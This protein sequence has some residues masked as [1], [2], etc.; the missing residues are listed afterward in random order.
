MLVSTGG[1]R[2]AWLV[3]GVLSFAPASAQARMDI[4][5]VTSASLE[6]AEVDASPGTSKDR[7]SA[8]RKRSRGANTCPRRRFPQDLNA[9]LKTLPASSDPDG[10]GFT[11]G[12]EL[13]DFAFDPRADPGRFNPLIADVPRIGI[14][15]KDLSLALSTT[16]SEFGDGGGDERRDHRGR[17]HAAPSPTVTPPRRSRAIRS[18]PASK[19]R[20]RA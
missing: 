12:E 1:R 20:R 17:D 10:D 5:P 4:G 8:A 13:Q 16:L 9:L 14:D 7:R 2:A 15:L 11:T 18:A 3:L 6:S 19:A